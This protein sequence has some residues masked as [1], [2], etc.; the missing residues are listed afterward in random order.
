MAIPCSIKLDRLYY[1]VVNNYYINELHENPKKYTG[2][3]DRCEYGRNIRD[4]LTIIFANIITTKRTA[5]CQ[6]NKQKNET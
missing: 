4:S 1:H 2:G 3:A 5:K 6:V